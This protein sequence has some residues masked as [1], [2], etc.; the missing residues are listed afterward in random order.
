MSLGVLGPRPWP[1]DLARSSL[2]I[3]AVKKFK[4]FNIKN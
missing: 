3:T 2:V 1:F 4:I